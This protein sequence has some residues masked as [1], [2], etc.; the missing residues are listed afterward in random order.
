MNSRRS[1]PA[2]AERRVARG[3]R[4]LQDL[5]GVAPL[6]FVA[7]TWRRGALTLPALERHGL[8]YLMGLA[9]L[10]RP[11]R[12]AVPLATWSWDLGRFAAAGWL[13]ELTGGTLTLRRR[14]V[15]CVVIHPADVARGYLPR[16]L[17]RIEGLLAQGYH[18]ALPR[19][20]L[21]RC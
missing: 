13:G 6:G 14:A 11:G 5:F 9:A 17:R 18:P 7:P 4:L 20:F 2:R 1:P 19:E 3:V 21:E 12:P 16:A 8:A 10:E 15:P